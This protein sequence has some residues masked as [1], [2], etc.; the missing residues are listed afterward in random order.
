MRS[1]P[2]VSV[3]GRFY[4][5]NNNDFDLRCPGVYYNHILIKMLISD[6]PSD[7]SIP[8]IAQKGNQ[9]NTCRVFGS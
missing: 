3:P 2:Q 6:C 4:T 8:E 9:K 7:G 5:K 1:T